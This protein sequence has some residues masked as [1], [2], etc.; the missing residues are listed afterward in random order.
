MK[1]RILFALLLF[2]ILSI[3]LFYYDYFNRAKGSS[4][5]TT[6]PKP[7][8]TTQIPEQNIDTPSDI[9]LHEALQ[10]KDDMPSP[11]THN[12]E[13]LESV[14]RRDVN[15]IDIVENPDGSRT[16]HLNGTYRTVSAAKRLP[17]GTLK[18]SCFENFEA[19]KDFISNPASVESK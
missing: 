7:A 5:E 17:D 9:R 14:M 8:I 6:P 3:G 18:I 16:A 1:S 19:L 2:F 4:V 15:N 13:L 10:T 11:T 12:L